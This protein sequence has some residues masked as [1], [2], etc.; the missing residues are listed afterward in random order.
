MAKIGIIQVLGLGDCVMILPIAKWYHD[1]GNEIYIALDSKFCEQFQ[2]AVPYATFV[3][4][5]DETLT[6]ELGVYNSYWY[7][8]PYRLLQER[9]C[10]AII[11]FPFHEALHHAVL[12]GPETH[13]DAIKVIEQRFGG[14][15]ER[16]A[17]TSKA[18][19]HLKFDEFKYA[20]AGVPFKQKWQLELQRNFQREQALYER[21]V[22]PTK[23]LLVCHLMTSQRE[24]SFHIDPKSIP[25]DS[26]TTQLVCIDPKETNNIFDWLGIL[27]R[28]TSVI[29]VDSVFFNLVDQL[30]FEIPGGKH[31]IRRSPREFTP[32]LG[33]GWS[34][35]NVNLPTDR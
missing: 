1:R 9:G 29:L 11:S 14:R 6:P 21:L 7:E 3:P 18:F 19:Q 27:E 25:Y 13:P 17:F 22:D 28:A 2:S 32:V 4:V 20:V 15:P 8:H 30:N 26:T 35:I 24:S 31:F 10:E 33:N 5:S 34:F 23:E 12:T 16:N